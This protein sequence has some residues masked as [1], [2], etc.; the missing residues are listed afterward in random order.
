MNKDNLTEYGSVNSDTRP[1]LMKSS[2][3]ASFTPDDGYNDNDLANTTTTT[4]NKNKFMNMNLSQIFDKI[5]NILPNT[6]ND[7]YQK[8]LEVKLKNN[9]DMDISNNDMF[10][11]T[12]IKFLF[13]NENIIYLG[14]LLLIITL[15]LYII[16]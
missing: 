9:S 11:E 13:E 6:Y 10:K 1:E 15:F 4:V 12:I 2:D 14:I 16:S 3:F 5:I 8:Q 7:F